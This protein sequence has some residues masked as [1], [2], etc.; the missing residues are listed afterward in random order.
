M[1]QTKLTKVGN[2]LALIIAKPIAESLDFH[3]GTPVGLRAEGNTLVVQKSPRSESMKE[4]LAM[5]D[6][7]QPMSDEDRLWLNRKPVGREE[8]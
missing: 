3:L 8:L 1:Y 6:L 7:S 5:C 2:S 4:M